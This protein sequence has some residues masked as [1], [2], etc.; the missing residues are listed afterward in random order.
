MCPQWILS[1]LRNKER[2]AQTNSLKRMYLCAWICHRNPIYHFSLSC[3][4]CYLYSVLQRLS[5]Y[6]Y[7]A[8][9]ISFVNA[10][11]TFF[12]VSQKYY[13]TF[14]QYRIS[15]KSNVNSYNTQPSLLSALMEQLHVL[16][17]ENVKFILWIWNL[18][19]MLFSV[20]L[21]TPLLKCS[22]LKVLIQN[23]LVSK[24]HR[25]RSWSF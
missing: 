7:N 15:V 3:L 24:T 5:V 10:Y 6:D 14:P 19:K 9:R 2:K 1:K 17:I 11:N 16:R 21:L 13:T 23:L 4:V 20:L 18:D 22:L 25:L 12:N 8:D